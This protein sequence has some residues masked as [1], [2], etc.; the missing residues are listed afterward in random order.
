[1]NIKTFNIHVLAIVAFFAIVN[2]SCKSSS[3]G[4]SSI[5]PDTIVTSDVFG[6][7]QEIDLTD[8]G[9]LLTMNAPIDALVRFYDQALEKAVTIEKG[10]FSVIVDQYS[11]YADESGDAKT[12]K[13]HRLGKSKERKDF[14]KIIY[15]ND[16]SYVYETNDQ[17]LGTDY[18]F[19][20]VSF[21]DGKEYNFSDG[22]NIQNYTQEEAIAMLQSVRQ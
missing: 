19:F 5:D 14:S 9:I 16:D 17:E 12:V 8:K 22:F 2:F 4:N 13:E 6:E 20:H 7:M 21:K 1:M 10:K 3:N 18:H 15:E 11:E